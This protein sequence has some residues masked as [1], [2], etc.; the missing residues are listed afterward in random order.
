MQLSNHVRTCVPRILYDEQEY[1]LNRKRGMDESRFGFLIQMLSS[2]FLNEWIRNE[3]GSESDA[4][5]F[6]ILSKQV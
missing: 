4:V 1:N 2:D 6:S 5:L 3:A